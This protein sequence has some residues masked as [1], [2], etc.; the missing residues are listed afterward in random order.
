MGDHPMALRAVCYGT[1]KTTQYMPQ[2]R[3][4]AHGAGCGVV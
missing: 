2:A 3:M 1:A 4:A